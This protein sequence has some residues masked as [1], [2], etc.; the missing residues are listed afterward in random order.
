ML[1]T[2]RLTKKF[3]GLYALRDLD[4]E[5]DDALVSGLIGPNGSGKST[6]INIVSGFDTATSGKVFY[7]GREL[8]RSSPH[9]R[10]ALGMVRTFQHPRPFKDMT[11]LDNVLISCLRMET[12]VSSARQK[13]LE[14]LEMFRLEKIKDQKMSKVNTSTARLVAIA[15]AF[16][17]K[18]RFIMIDE[19]A[20][21]LNAAELKKFTEILRSLHERGIGLLVV[22]HVMK[23]ISDLCDEVIVLDNGEKIAQ[24]KPVDIMR[25]KEVIQAYLG[26]RHAP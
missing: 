12:D 13:A 11:V 16:S 26:V 6:F 4:L 23:I 21:G 7:K 18:A 20:A 2:E 22:E 10:V 1:K 17:T 9:Q 3:G 15:G 25:S 5:I 14:V 8:R 19:G 24:G